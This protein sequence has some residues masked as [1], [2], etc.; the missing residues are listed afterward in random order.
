METI[1]P[2]FLWISKATATPYTG[3]KSLIEMEEFQ[4]PAWKVYWTAENDSKVVE[5]TDKILTI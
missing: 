2:K 5:C 3:K 1:H 4:M